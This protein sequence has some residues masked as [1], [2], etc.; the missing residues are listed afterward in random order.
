MTFDKIHILIIIEQEHEVFWL[1]GYL[2]KML[3]ITCPEYFKEYYKC[4]VSKKKQVKNA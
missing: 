2:L 1:L 3:L 4:L